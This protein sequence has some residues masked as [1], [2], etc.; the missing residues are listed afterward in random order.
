MIV[1]SAGYEEDWIEGL[2]VYHNPNAEIP[3]P[4]EM[5]PGAAHYFCDKAGQVTSHTPH[6]HPI[7]SITKHYCPVDVDKVLAKAGDKTH[8]VWTP[9]PGKAE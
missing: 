6:F 1:N 4:M 3:L 7:T 9:K 8:V 2:N 5:F